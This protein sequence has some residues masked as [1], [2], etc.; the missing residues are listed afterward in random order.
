[1]KEKISVLIPAYNEEKGIKK[2]LDSCLNQTKIPDE[3]VVVNDGSNVYEWLPK[4]KKK[5]EETFKINLDE[6]EKEMGE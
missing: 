2:T 5:L 3:I 1:M 6:K 4:L